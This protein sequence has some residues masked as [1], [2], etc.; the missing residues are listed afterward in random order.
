MQSGNIKDL[1]GISRAPFLVLT[2]IVLFPAL[3]LSYKLTGQIALDILVLVF[4]AAMAAHIAVNAL[5]EYQDFNSGLDQITSRT[6]FSGGSG[7]LPSKPWLVAWVR[8]VFVVAFL[9]MA[10]IGGYLSWR[11]GHEILPLGILGTLIILSYTQWL[12]RMPLACLVAPGVGFGLL[13]VNGTVFLM[14]GSFSSSSQY[15]GW[16][17]FFLCN[18][19]LLLNQIPDIEPDKVIGRRHLPILLGARPM[20]WVYMLLLVGAYGS[21]VVGCWLGALPLTT[22]I[23]CATLPLGLFVCRG[24]LRS[25]QPHSAPLENMPELVSALGRNVVLVLLTPLMAGVGILLS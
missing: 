13:M 5:N 14:T 15:L 1:L 17:V 23:A 21:L 25:T 24:L 2:P 9:V 12:N 6:P 18:A 7:T 22:L 10:V 19:L 11:V 8:V 16:M 20:V 4:F 3:A